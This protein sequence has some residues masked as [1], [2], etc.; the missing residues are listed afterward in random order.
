MVNLTMVPAACHGVAP[1]ADGS[2]LCAGCVSHVR[3]LSREGSSCRALDEVAIV[4]KTLVAGNVPVPGT[5]S[6]M[7]PLI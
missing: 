5:A 7:D 4:E 3:A 6:S 1:R 2:W